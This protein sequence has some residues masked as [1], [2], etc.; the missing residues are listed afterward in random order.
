[1][2]KDE[3]HAISFFSL[4]LTVALL[5]LPNVAMCQTTR[6]QSGLTSPDVQEVGFKSTLTSLAEK[7]HIGF[8]AEASPF[9]DTLPSTKIPI[10]SGLSAL[11]AV[12]KVANAFDYDASNL[13]NLFIL[14][15]RYTDAVDI[16]SL[17]PEECKTVLADLVKIVRMFKN[18]SEPFLNGTLNMFYINRLFYGL[19]PE[20]KKIV[21]NKYLPIEQIPVEQ[22]KHIQNVV[23]NVFIDRLAGYVDQADRAVQYSDNGY[24]TLIN[25]SLLSF[26]YPYE[27][28]SAGQP[29]HKSG[30]SFRFVGSTN[31]N[32]TP[33][34]I[35][36][37]EQKPSTLAEAAK[38]SKSDGKVIVDASVTSKPIIMVG[39][40]QISVSWQRFASS[41]AEVY[42][43]T[44]ITQP[45]G[46][47]LITQRRATMPVFIVDVHPCVRRALPENLLRFFTYRLPPVIN[48]KFKAS[49]QVPGD[50]ES[51]QRF[52]FSSQRG[53]GAARIVWIG[54]LRAKSVSKSRVPLALLNDKEQSAFC[55]SLFQDIVREVADS[56]EAPII[57]RY[58]D[59]LLLNCPR[60]EKDEDGQYLIGFTLG[61]PNE[62][63]VIVPLMMTAAQDWQSTPEKFLPAK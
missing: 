13:G 32:K 37:A 58:F 26:E 62:S 8:I 14:K 53:S 27:F 49:T 31:N 25:S 38:H 9:H 30:F 22:R 1:M 16:P 41:L 61:L 56:E 39:V 19:S 5:L 50:D 7:F 2:K 40:D 29:M 46:T 51:S 43:L 63:G 35:V 21:Q 34:Q 17:S 36:T 55:V 4:C 57:L 59:S 11:S 60:Q 42:G 12:R 23:A 20:N 3:N 6:A 54:Y 45:N 33:L 52:A 15:K 10:V 47:I 28:T 24:F 44:T 18:P 48:K